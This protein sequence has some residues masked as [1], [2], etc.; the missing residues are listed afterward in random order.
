MVAIMYMSSCPWGTSVHGVN[1]EGAEGELDINTV[2]V[3]E[4]WPTH[5]REEHAERTPARSQHWRPDGPMDIAQN[6]LAT[7]THITC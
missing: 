2:T 1:I 5:E 7:V 3:R 6:I 4:F